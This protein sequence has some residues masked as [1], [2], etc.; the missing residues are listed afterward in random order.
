MC[1]FGSVYEGYIVGAV[2]VHPLLKFVCASYQGSSPS[3]NKPFVY[4]GCSLL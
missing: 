2:L 1:V 3:L 4:L